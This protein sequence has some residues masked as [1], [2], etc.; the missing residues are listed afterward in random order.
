[1]IQSVYVCVCEYVRVERRRRAGRGYVFFRLRNNKERFRFY[2]L[3]F[4]YVVAKPKNQIT[5]KFMNNSVKRDKIMKKHQTALRFTNK[6][7]L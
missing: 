5:M 3:F 7:L 4:F 2:F 6:H 1:M